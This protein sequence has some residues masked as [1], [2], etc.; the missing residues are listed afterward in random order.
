MLDV[1]LFHGA[2]YLLHVPYA[3]GV[4][5][6]GPGAV[7]SCHDNRGEDADNPDHDKQFN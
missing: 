1:V 7:D 2:G 6:F 3:F 5:A 4:P